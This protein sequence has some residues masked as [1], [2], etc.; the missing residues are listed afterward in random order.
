LLRTGITRPALSPDSGANPS[1]A[2][3]LA[4][5]STRFRTRSRPQTQRNPA[6]AADSCHT[7]N[8]TKPAALIASA[9]PPNPVRASVRR[10]DPLRVLTNVTTPTTAAL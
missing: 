5:A 7:A 3:A 4:T 1:I 10:R 8:A 2:I 6:A 9:S